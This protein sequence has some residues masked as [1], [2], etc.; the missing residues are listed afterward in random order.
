MVQ[1]GTF[2]GLLWALYDIEGEQNMSL[3][4]VPLWHQDYCELIM[5][6]ESPAET[7]HPGQEITETICM[8]YFITGDPRKEHGTNR[9]PSTRRIRVESLEANRRCESMSSQNPPRWTPSWLSDVWATGKDPESERSARDTPETNRVTPE[10]NRVTQESSWVTLPSCSPPSWPF[11]IT[12]LA[13]S[14]CVSSDNSLLSVRQLSDSRETWE[15]S[16]FLKQLFWRND[17][18]S[19]EKKSRKVLFC[20]INLYLNLHL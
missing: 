5:S 6:G 12:S 8:S 15:G 20:K 19:S 13:L 2:L 17:R 18:K 14:A 16:P 7:A 10:T 3:P 9:S 11:S 1:V 4:K